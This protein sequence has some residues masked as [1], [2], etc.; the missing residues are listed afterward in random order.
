MTK[1]E[2]EHHALKEAVLVLETIKMTMTG[3]EW[4]APALAEMVCNVLARISVLAPDVVSID[5][6]D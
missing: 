4:F 2:R 3:Y 6:A 1:R 5:H